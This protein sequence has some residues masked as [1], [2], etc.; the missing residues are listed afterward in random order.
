MLITGAQKVESPSWMFVKAR[1]SRPIWLP[2]RV[3]S[4]RLKEQL[5]V[6]GSTVFEATVER[7]L[8]EVEV[9]LVRQTE[10]QEGEE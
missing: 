4:E 10:M 3:Q 6:M 7:R 8:S 5:A 9:A 1:P 2:V